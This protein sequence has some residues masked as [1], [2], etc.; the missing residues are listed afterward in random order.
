MHWS[1]T[2]IDY[3]R[4]IMIGLSITPALF[5]NAANAI[6]G[7]D[8]TDSLKAALKVSKMWSHNFL[9][10]T[11][12]KTKRHM[13]RT[14]VVAPGIARVER[15]FAMLKSCSRIQGQGFYNFDKTC[16]QISQGH[17]DIVHIQKLESYSHTRQSGSGISSPLGSAILFIYYY[18]LL[19]LLFLLPLRAWDIKSQS[20]DW[21]E[22]FS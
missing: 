18:R 21:E 5:K 1:H 10:Q 11:H 22:T 4:W 8:N 17:D 6:L 20:D 14:F 13:I 16:F 7:W 9:K 15:W 19:F 3:V 12:K 2:S